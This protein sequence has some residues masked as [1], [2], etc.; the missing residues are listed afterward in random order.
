MLSIRAEKETEVRCDKLAHTVAALQVRTDFAASEKV[1][2]SI[3][4]YASGL[5]DMA[6][7]TVDIYF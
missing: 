4:C 2:F 3:R 7:A 1:Q 6:A 5:R